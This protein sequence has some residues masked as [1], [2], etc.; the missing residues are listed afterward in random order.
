MPRPLPTST[1]K[2]VS[3]VKV[4][5]Y[6][7][8]PSARGLGPCRCLSRLCCATTGG[9]STG[10]EATY[11]A[12][13][14]EPLCSGGPGV[15]YGVWGGFMRRST[16]RSQQKH[17]LQTLQDMPQA[18]T[19]RTS[20]L[21]TFFLGGSQMDAV[22]SKLGD[23]VYGTTPVYALRAPRQILLQCEK[24]PT[25]FIPPPPPRGLFWDG[26]GGISKR[27]R[28]NRARK[29]VLFFATITSPNSLTR[30]SLH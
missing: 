23:R 6:H 18:K 14:A 22:P 20:R 24:L 1:K 16:L 28:T 13:L 15:G 17:G 9:A 3:W 7:P 19:R 26:G 8:V 4:A 27:F 25:T 12:H 29:N 30:G 11:P 10:F 2:V 21:G 5:C